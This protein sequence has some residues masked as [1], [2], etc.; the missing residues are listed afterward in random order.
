MKVRAAS[1]KVCPDW[2]IG[3]GGPSWVFTDEIVVD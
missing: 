3:A 2:H 1:A